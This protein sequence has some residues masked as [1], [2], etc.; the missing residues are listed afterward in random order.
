[1]GVKF[2]KVLWLKPECL[3]RHSGDRGFFIEAFFHWLVL[4]PKSNTGGKCERVVLGRAG[5]EEVG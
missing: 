1:M 3:P 2:N 4:K 5:G